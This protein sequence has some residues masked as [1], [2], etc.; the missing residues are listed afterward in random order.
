MK[1]F[2]LTSSMLVALMAVLGAQDNSKPWFKQPW[3]ASKI[4]PCDRACLVQFIDE[5][6][7]AVVKKDKAAVPISEETWY[8]ENTARLQIGEGVPWRAT[9]APTSFMIH[10][11]DPVTGQVAVP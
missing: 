2:L 8:T 7:A 6:I 11:A 3:D 4:K 10:A 9:V 1:G 5:Y